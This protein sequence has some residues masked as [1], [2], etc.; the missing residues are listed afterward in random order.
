MSPFVGRER[1]LIELESTLGDLVGGKG[2]L[3]LVSG[4]AGIG[5]SRL[6]QEV[7]DRAEARGVKVGW[8]RCWESGT[9]PPFA[10][11]EQLLRQVAEGT[12]AEVPVS[13]TD[14]PDLVR[15]RYFD[16]VVAQVRRVA[17][18]HPLL[19]VVDDLHWADVASVHLLA[20]LASSRPDMPVV[21][22]GTYAATSWKLEARWARRFWRSPALGATCRSPAYRRATCLSS[23]AR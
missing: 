22:M 11:W 2:G 13:P 12:I 21:T 8:A 3:V 20:Y 18:R 23:S 16:D 5:K 9:Q 1:E 10:P 19:V 6:C 15:M 7:A 17:A 14:D 4:E